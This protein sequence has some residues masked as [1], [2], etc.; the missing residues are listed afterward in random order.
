ME[1]SLIDRIITASSFIEDGFFMESSFAEEG[2]FTEG[3]LVDGI[4]EQLHREGQLHGAQ[5][6]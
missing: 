2:V 5:P 1:S 3:S 4:R 6:R